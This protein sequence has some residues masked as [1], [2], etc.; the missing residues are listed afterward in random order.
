MR[1]VSIFN[2]LCR[3]V[4]TMDTSN[5]PLPPILDFEASSLSDTSYPISAGLVVAGEVYYWVIK[6]QPDWIDWSLESQAI[7]GIKRSFL[8]DHGLPVCQVYTEITEKL[9][10]HEVIYSDAPAWEGLW[11][12]RLGAFNLRIANIS[13]LISI[14][15]RECFSNE[16]ANTF[17]SNKLMQHR[18]DH[19]ALAIAL[20][21]KKLR[22]N[23][24]SEDGL[25]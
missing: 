1:L 5:N 3:A 17:A 24:V 14:D 11:L 8:E 16:L 2:V 12:Q 9:N 25:K 7:H 18:A 20:T 6:P 15:Q 23:Q 4:H 13:E 10:G 19:D 21:V 22:R